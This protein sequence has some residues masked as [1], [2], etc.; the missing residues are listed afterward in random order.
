MRWLIRIAAVFGVAALGLVSWVYLASERHL[1]SFERPAAF[2]FPV[3]SS[4]STIA[5]GD[6]LVRTR[7]CRG[8]HGDDLGGQQ[9]WGHAV[10]PDLAVYARTETAATFEAALRHGIGRDGK[11]LYSMPSYNFVRMLDEDVAAMYAYLATVPVVDRQLPKAALPWEVR[12]EMA[13]GLD[14]AIP[15]YLDLVPPLHR[16]GDSNPAIA[17]GEYIAMTTCNE[18]HGFGLRADSP[19]DE[20]TAPDLLI[21]MA[22]D[23]AAFLHLMRTGKA[24]GDRELRMMSGVARGRFAYFTDQEIDDVYSFL[25]DMS[26]RASAPP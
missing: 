18:C 11:A 15:A 12:L 14:A 19:W 21:I 26:A 13:R 10:A 1:G 8:C 4:P 20:D 17:R 25:T 24:L 5:R 7:G 3:D 16:S 2:V 9:M 6:H 23:K 22:Y